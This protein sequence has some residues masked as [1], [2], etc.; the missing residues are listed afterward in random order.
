MFGIF[1]KKKA[2]IKAVVKKLEN[3]ELMQAIV[4]G[5]IWVAAADGE[6]DSK[7]IARLEA[8]IKTNDKLAHFGA[9]ITS[10]LNRYREKFEL[11]G[12]PVLR[13]EARKELQDTAHNESDA[14]E[15][16]VNMISIALAGDGSIDEHEEKALKEAGTILNQRLEDFI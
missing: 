5:A 12:M 14:A 4:A 16:F 13:F 8:I 2:E 6:I 3:R 7:E 9:E 1:G 15:V 10:N 11:V